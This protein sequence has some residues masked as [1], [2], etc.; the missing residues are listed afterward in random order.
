LYVFDLQRFVAKPMPSGSNHS[1]SDSSAP[2]QCIVVAPHGPHRGAAS[3]LVDESGQH[4]Q[5]CRV[6]HQVSTQQDDRRVILAK[7]IE[8]LHCDPLL[9]GRAK[10]E[11]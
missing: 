9:V 2:N 1:L 7:S 4:F 10:M 8:K 6:V 3:K 11:I 5:T